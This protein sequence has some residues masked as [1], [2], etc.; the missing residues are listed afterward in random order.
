MYDNTVVASI[1]LSLGLVGAIMRVSLDIHQKK[2]REKLARDT[3]GTVLT[4]GGSITES[5]N[6]MSAVIERSSHI[7]GS[8][9]SVFN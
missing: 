5:I 9:N 6:S 1:F 2:M 3:L 4:L 8:E 7:S